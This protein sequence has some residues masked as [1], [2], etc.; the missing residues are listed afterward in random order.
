MLEVKD[1]LEMLQRMA[2]FASLADFA[3]SCGI[4]DATMR[5]HIARESVPYERALQ[6][7][8]AAA[9]RGVSVTTDWIMAGK[10]PAPITGA[11][12]ADLHTV[13]DVSSAILQNGEGEGTD[14]QP[15]Q[16]SSGQI[17]FFESLEKPG[18]LMQIA[19]SSP[20]LIMGRPDWSVSKNDFTLYVNTDVMD[21]AIERG[22][23]ILINTRSPPTK[24]D[25]VILM[26]DETPEGRIVAIRRLLVITDETLTCEQLSPQKT[27]PFDR[28]IWTAYHRIQEIRKK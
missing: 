26:Q 10:G 3:R 24:R 27:E 9:K 17:K 21:P 13:R 25:L 19:W 12:Y 23:R 15:A 2:R 14:P 20:S 1:R 6:Y 7:Q 16:H 5:Q 4:N 18:G 8:R 28:L 22:D 11:R